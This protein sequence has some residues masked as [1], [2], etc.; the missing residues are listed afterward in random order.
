MHFSSVLFSAGLTV[1]KV[2]RLQTS[3]RYSL[4]SP[5]VRQNNARFYLMLPNGLWA[6]KKGQ[7]LKDWFPMFQFPSYSVTVP[8]ENSMKLYE[9]GWTCR[10]Q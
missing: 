5:Q 8:K 6:R 10:K 4:T 2:V 3:H 1:A 9:L 7:E